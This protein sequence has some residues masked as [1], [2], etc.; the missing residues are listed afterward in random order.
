MAKY[1]G[2]GQEYSWMSEFT[3]IHKNIPEYVGI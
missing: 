3:L 2:I 1:V